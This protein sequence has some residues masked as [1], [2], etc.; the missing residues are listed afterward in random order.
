VI[1]G[2]RYMRGG[3]RRRR[4]FLRPRGWGILVGFVDLPHLFNMRFKTL[5]GYF[6]TRDLRVDRGG[7]SIQIVELLGA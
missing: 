1:E 6:I 2:G 3:V 7:F 4:E 5:D